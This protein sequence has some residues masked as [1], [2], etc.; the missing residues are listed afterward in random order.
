MVMQRKLTMDYDGN[1]RVYSRKN[2]SENW[3]VSWQ[4]ISDTCIIHG[5]CGANSTCSYDPKKGK[6]CSC[7]PGYK[8]KNHSDFSSGCEPMFDFTCNRS[9]STFL[10]LNG[11]E[12][13][14]YD[15]YFVQNSTYKNCESLCLQDCNCMGFQYKYEEGQNIFKC[16]TKLQLLN[17]RHSPSFVGTAHT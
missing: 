14:G 12:L 2:M 16:Y 7:L 10:K 4:V 11:F 17:G 1:V 3:Y 5:V 15:K 13:Y 8:V 9:E 6:K